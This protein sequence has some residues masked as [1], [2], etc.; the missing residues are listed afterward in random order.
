LPNPDAGAVETGGATGC[1]TS[2]MSALMLCPAGAY[3][4]T[5][6]VYFPALAGTC[7]TSGSEEEA[8]DAT[9]RPFASSR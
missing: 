3:G 2:A 4:T 5:R 9:S 1:P 8:D 6:T 7:M